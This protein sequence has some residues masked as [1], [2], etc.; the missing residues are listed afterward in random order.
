MS[1]DPIKVSYSTLADLK[2]QLTDLSLAFDNTVP[3][4]S[5]GEQNVTEGAGELAPQLAYGLA[6][7]SLAWKSSLTAMGDG[8]A[9][10]GNNA[11][12]AAVDFAAVD[13]SYSSTITL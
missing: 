10:I 7:F 4:V 11:G 12:Q 2:H 6:A 13:V 3:G 8:A 9:L 1:D 5:S